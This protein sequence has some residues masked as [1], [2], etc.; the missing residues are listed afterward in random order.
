MRI[1]K[2][3]A[4]MTFLLA[5]IIMGIS[6]TSA[7]LVVYADTDGTELRTTAQP[8]KLILQLGDG[9]AD[10]AFELRLDYGVF[11]VPI[12]T[13][14]SGI[15]T[16]ELGGSRTYTLS[17]LIQLSAE[18]S[19]ETAEIYQSDA[20]ILKSGMETMPDSET[21]QPDHQIPVLPLILFLSGIILAAIW[22]LIMRAMK[23]RREYSN[24]D[25]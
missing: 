18:E 3:K 15:L 14:S 11:S 9:W 12:K 5:I 8:D 16:M 13:D 21:E 17:R 19:S 7:L 23:K 22:L 25:E 2:I 10:T 20:D 1:R 24:D 4:K 6:V